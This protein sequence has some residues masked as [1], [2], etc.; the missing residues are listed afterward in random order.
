MVHAMIIHWIKQSQ[1]N[2]TRCGVAQYAQHIAVQPI[3]TGQLLNNFMLPS[4]DT[5]C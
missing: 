2:L 4:I 1:Q 5:Q 3:K